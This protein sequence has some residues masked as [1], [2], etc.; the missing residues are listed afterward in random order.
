MNSNLSLSIIL[1]LFLNVILNNILVD[2]K[3]SLF[4]IFCHILIPS[5]NPNS[6][7]LLECISFSNS[8]NFNFN[9]PFVIICIVYYSYYK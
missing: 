2:I 3:E 5:V 7:S 8:L 1:L 9:I 4:L 6:I